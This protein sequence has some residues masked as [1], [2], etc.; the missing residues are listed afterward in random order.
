[1]VSESTEPFCLN[2][3]PSTTPG[4]STAASTQFLRRRRWPSSERERLGTS[5]ISHN[6]LP[7]G[8]AISELSYGSLALRPV[9]LFAPLADPTK[10][11]CSANGGFYFRA[12][13]ELVSR[14]IA[15]YRYR[16]NW[17]SSTG[18][19]LHPLE[20]QLA[21]LHHARQPVGHALPALRRVRV[22]LTRVL[23]GWDRTRARQL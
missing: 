22:R 5:N 4:S 20:W 15:G 17:A 3:S 6:P 18:G 12:F 2:M 1:V 19:V 13:D 10:H 14:F 7:V 21:S 11:L 9:E 16:G 8:G 23:L